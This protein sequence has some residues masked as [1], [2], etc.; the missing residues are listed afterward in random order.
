AHRLTM[1]GTETSLLSLGQGWQGVVVGEIVAVEPHPD[2]DRLR[3]VTVGLAVEKQTVVCGAPNLQLGDKIA[4]APV[5]TGLIDGHT[6]EKS[7][8]KKAKIR[9]VTSCGMVCS[10]KELGISDSHEGIMVL[11]SEAIPGTPLADYLGDTVLDLEITPNRPDLLSVIGVAREVAALTGQCVSISEP[12]FEA[13]GAPIEEQI[14]VEIAD[15]DLCPRYCASLITGIKIDESPEWLKQRLASSGMRPINNI[16]DA[17]NYVMLEYGQPLHGFDYNKIRDKKIIVRRARGGEVMVSLDGVERN[18]TREMLVIADSQRAVAIGGVMGGANSE[19]SEETTSILL[20]AASFKPSSIHFTSHRL[21]LVSEASMRFERAIRAELTL[22]ALKRATQLI[23]QLAGGK[24]AQGLID[25]YPGKKEQKPIL[26][27]VERANR[28]LGAEFNPKQMSNALTSLGCDIKPAS[29]AAEFLVTAPYW[30]SDIN[31]EEDLI[32]E[33]ARVIGYDRIPTTILSGKLPQQSHKPIIGLRKKVNR[34]LIGFGF[35]EVITYSLTSREVMAKISQNPIEPETISLANPMTAEQDCL[36][37]SLR[38]NLLIALEA[39][40]R[41]EDGPIMLFELG[42]VYLSCGNDLPDEPEVLCG[43]ISSSGVEKSW[44]D[45]KEPIDFFD[46]KGVVEGLLS[47]LGLEA[48]FEEGNDDGLR[49][50]RRLSIVI[51]GDRLGVVGEL[52]PGVAEAF[53]ISGEVYLFEMDVAALL[54]HTLGYK[55]FQPIPRFPAVIRDIA[56]VLD[57]D[58]THQQVADIIRGFPLIKE[59][60]LFDIYTGKQLPAGKKSL[61]YRISFQSPEHTLTDEEADKV[62]RKI[63]KKLSGELGASLRG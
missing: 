25:I 49:P 36:R 20:E 10:E 61:A 18:L 34:I 56:L 50:G 58:V 24:T 13:Q 6:G 39:N 47:Q 19:V 52:H 12:G 54:P 8:L 44:H 1:A 51:G 9:G 42:K 28:I 5:G 15:P 7:V 3:L 22:P 45:S 38:G 46:A 63:L 16:V 31:L 23:V 21:G 33:V 32:E 37:T 48:S 40:R 41:H 53:D 57:N 59:V 11:P 29:S 4:F 30:R 55:T 17:T 43:L 14:S 60:A 2:A 27:R 62:Q 35:Q 26:L